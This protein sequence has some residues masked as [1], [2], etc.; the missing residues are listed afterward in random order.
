MKDK[1][2]QNSLIHQ[3]PAGLL[4][5]DF[6]TEVFAERQTKKVFLI[7]NGQT[8]P[9]NQLDSYKKSQI[10]QNY[11]SDEVAVKDLSH[12]SENEALNQY[13]FCVLG[14]ADSNA[15]F[16]CDG[17][18]KADDN[19]ICSNNCQCLK[20]KSKNITVNGIA[21]SKRKIEIIQLL[22]TDLCC[23]QIADKLCITEST[24]DTHK[25]QLFKLFKVH[26]TTGL[27]REA[28]NQKIVQ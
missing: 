9:F 23:K 26:S 8:L 3:L 22:A 24:L 17:N 16:D 1:C 28:I 15:D 11:L 27:I 25:S 21:L 10:L 2:N 7:S 13:A 12:L 5:G 19:F 6:R 4:V 14:A 18:L 20:W